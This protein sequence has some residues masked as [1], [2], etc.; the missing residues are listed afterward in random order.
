MDKMT[1]TEI[2][3]IIHQSL[4]FHKKLINSEKIIN[5]PLKDLIMLINFP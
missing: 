3:G 1:I 4:A 5:L 2:I